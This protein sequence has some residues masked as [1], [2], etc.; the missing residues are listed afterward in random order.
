[1]GNYSSKE[2]SAE[3]EGNGIPSRAGTEVK[4]DDPV[5]PTYLMV[6]LSLSERQLVMEFSQQQEVNLE[7][8]SGG[9]GI[10]EGNSINFDQLKFLEYVPTVFRWE[11]GGRNVYITG[12][13]NNWDKQVFQ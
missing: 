3:E 9:S 4:T 5:Y 12:T 2:I 1:M 6:R 10:D 11:H 13:F 7:D 8:P